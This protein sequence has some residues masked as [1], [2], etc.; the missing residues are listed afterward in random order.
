MYKV[1]KSD[2]DAYITNRVIKSHR[3]TDSNVGS[4]GTLDLFKL[5]GSTTSG[6]TINTELS[7]LLVH[8]NLDP[9]R[10]LVSSGKVD[11]NS[12]SFNCTLKLFDVY[13]GQP[14]PS[15]FTVTV[16]A[17]S[18]SFD[19][20]LGKD[21]VYYADTDVCNFLSG[22]RTQGAWLMSGCALSGGLPGLVDYVTAS[23]TILSGASLRKTQLFTTGEENLEVN[24]TT[25]VSATI[26]GLLPDEGFRISLDD[27]LETNQRTYFVKRFASR[28]AYNEDKR[29]K[30]IVKYDDSILDDSRSL[31]LDSTSNI[32]LFNYVHHQLTNLKSGSLLTQITGSNSLLLKLMTEISGGT[33]TLTFTGSQHKNGINFVTGTYSASIL[34][35]ST[36]STFVSKLVQSSSILMTPIWGSL[37]GMVA[38]HTG[39]KIRVYPPERGSLS[40]G[41]KKYV[42]SCNGL[43]ENH[44]SD[45]EVHVG[46]HI[47]DSSSPTIIASRAPV[48]LPGIVIRDVHYQVRN[49]TTGIIEIPFDTTYN[50]TRLSSDAKGMQFKLDM[51]NLTKNRSYVIDI[52]VLNG[53]N[54]FVY[55]DAS[56]VFRISDLR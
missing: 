30:L 18:R 44:F 20:G 2:R 8:Y 55:R 28:T 11:M 29:P 42:I 54:R 53:S 40:L 15:N 52:L 41:N 10:T 16:H 43:Q 37:D 17:L 19:E 12:T 33:Y 3:V 13:G 36:N 48:E 5:Y 7:R 25:L 46:V 56:P 35:E 6:S 31:Y 14:T 9:L 22:S 39:S 21:V 27:D 32:F 49:D 1:L 23:T 24:V 47:F 4:A 26:A 38:Y 45:D 50:S 34:L 51:S